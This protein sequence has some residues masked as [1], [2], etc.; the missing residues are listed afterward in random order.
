VAKKIILCIDDENTILNS[1]KTELKTIFPKDYLVEVAENGTDAIEIVEE[2]LTDRYDICLVISDYLMPQM[3]GDEVLKYIHQKSPKTIKIMLTGQATIEGV[4]NAIKDARLYRYIAKPWQQE[5]FKLTVTEAVSRYEQDIDLEEKNA[6]LE[7]LNLQQAELIEKLHENEQHLQSALAAELKLKEISSRFV[8]NEFL[9]LL[10][11]NNLIDLRLADAKQK[12]MS[13]L[14]C[15]IRNFTQLSEKM[16]PSENFEFI[17]SYLSYMEPVISGHRGFIDKYIGDAIMALFSESP[18]DAVGA[19]IAMLKRLQDYNQFRSSKSQSPINIGIGINTGSLILGTVGTE[20][21]MDG[22]VI[23][24]A[25]NL[26]ARIET[27]TKHYKVSLLITH[28]TFESLK[29]PSSY[30]IRMIDS[31]KVKGK[32]QLT[33]VYEVFDA[34]CEAIKTAK[35][36]SLATFNQALHCFNEQDFKHA[37]SLFSHCLADN[38]DDSVAQIYLNRI[39]GQMN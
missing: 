15:D 29:N 25:V 13:V 33:T 32:D 10:G 17:N 3:K 7:K 30:A 36:A 23:S 39:L 35:L 2:L 8:P 11:C 14:F 37:L 27:L 12:E 20:K 26:S 34:D 31:V 9:A 16:T 5:D 4:A 38:P 1:L 19:G 6:A 28:H 22:T 18:D 21:R 24:D